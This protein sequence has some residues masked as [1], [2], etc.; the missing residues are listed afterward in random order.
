MLLFTGDCRQ[1]EL[2]G[3]FPWLQSWHPNLHVG[4]VTKIGE[5]IDK[6]FED[7]IKVF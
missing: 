5:L 4:M 3:S 6:N 2:G 1:L 7:V